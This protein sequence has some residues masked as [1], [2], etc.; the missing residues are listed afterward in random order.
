MTDEFGVTAWGRDWVRIAQPTKIIRPNPAIPRARSLARKDCVG[1]VVVGAGSVIA[2]VA[3]TNDRRVTLTH[4]IWTPQQ[5]AAAHSLLVDGDLPDTLHAQM[6]RQGLPVAPQVDELTSTCDCPQR[7][8]PCVHIL[9]VYFEVARRIDENP[10]LAF[11]L[12][13]VDAKSDRYASRIPIT[14]IDPATFYS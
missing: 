7:A 3:G 11:V 5:V 13:G 8:R 4:P 14:Q 12:R 1:D 2:S 6:V 9:A 10:R